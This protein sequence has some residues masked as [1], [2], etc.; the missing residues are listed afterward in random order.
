[1][2]EK[3]ACSYK[4]TVV[5]TTLLKMNKRFPYYLVRGVLVEKFRSQPVLNLKMRISL[6]S[7]I[8]YPSSLI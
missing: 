4:K 7:H 5:L 2:H 1:M 3:N 6:I 8:K